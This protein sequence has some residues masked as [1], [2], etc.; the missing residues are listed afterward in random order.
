MVGRNIFSQE[1]SRDSKITKVSLTGQ[2]EFAIPRSREFDQNR[3][4][5]TLIR[6]RREMFGLT[7]PEHIPDENRFAN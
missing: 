6:R 3:A 4:R 1:Q 5:A 7:Q 2:N